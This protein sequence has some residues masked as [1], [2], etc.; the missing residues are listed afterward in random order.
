MNSPNQ[1]NTS[2]TKHSNDHDTTKRAGEENG[3]TMSHEEA[4]RLGAEARWG[5][6]SHQ[7]EHEER[8]PSRHQGSHRGSSSTKSNSQLQGA[9]NEEDSKDTIIRCL[10]EALNHYVRL[11]SGN[12]QGSSNNQSRAN[13]QEG[14]RSGSQSSRHPSMDEDNSEEDHTKS[15]SNS[16]RA[17]ASASR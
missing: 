13:R 5:K 15:S 8:N 1:K 16:S 3:H 4:G 17:H 7:D 11:N 6:D 9:D 14:G 2:S 12:Q 10:T